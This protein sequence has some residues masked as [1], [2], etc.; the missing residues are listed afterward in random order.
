[1]PVTYVAA[2]TLAERSR[3]TDTSPPGWVDGF[4][5]DP[6]KFLQD[7][8]QPFADAGTRL[9]L[10]NPFGR[11]GTTRTFLRRHDG[12]PASVTVVEWMPSSLYHEQFY[13]LRNFVSSP[14]LE[15]TFLYVG[16]P[17][18]YGLKDLAFAA[19]MLDTFRRNFPGAIPLYDNTG[20]IDGT[21]HCAGSALMAAHDAMGRV[22]FNSPVPWGVEP[23]PAIENENSPR[24]I[25][26]PS[27]IYGTPKT[28]EARSRIGLNAWH[29]W[30]HVDPI[31]AIRGD[32]Y[33]TP[34]LRLAAAREWGPKVAPYNGIVVVHGVSVAEMEG[35]T[36]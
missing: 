36:R 33:K 25:Y 23:N 11:G 30:S 31:V 32:D 20:D 14:G 18:I 24:E 6:T 3:V 28:W 27:F 10:H 16:A 8:A 4:D 15:G 7:R 5:K 29:S 12:Q 13:A 2:I 26:Q 21:E 35:L 22:P 34:E 19:F 17:D 1:M 9:L